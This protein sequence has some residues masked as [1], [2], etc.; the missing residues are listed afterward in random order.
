MDEDNTDYLSIKDFEYLHCAKKLGKLYFPN[1][2]KRD[3][4]APIF[5]RNKSFFIELNDLYETI[6]KCQINNQSI[7]SLEIISIIA[8]GDTVNLCDS[9]TYPGYTIE[10]IKSRNGL[11]WKNGWWRPKYISIDKKVPIQPKKAEFLVI[12]EKNPVPIEHIG[13]TSVRAI[14][15]YTGNTNIKINVRGIEQVI[16]SIKDGLNNIH[17]TNF[18]G[19]DKETVD[20][21]T[22]GVPIIFDHQ[23]RYIIAESGADYNYSAKTEWHFGKN[24]YFAIIKPTD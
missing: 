15:N 1:G 22:N 23:L 21:F 18:I 19:I 2:K 24:N 13:R 11:E 14:C 20:A 10:K 5:H 12:T 16:T 3:D 17:N 6:D 9:T 4:N 8:M 7:P